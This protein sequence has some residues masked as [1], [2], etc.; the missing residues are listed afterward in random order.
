MIRVRLQ[1]GLG[2]QMFQYALG[3]T[4]AARHKVPLVLDLSFYEQQSL[5]RFE[6]EAFNIQADIHKSRRQLFRESPLN[7]LNL[8]SLLRSGDNGTGATMLLEDT[9]AGVDA[10]VFDATPPLVLDGYWASYQYWRGWDGFRTDFTLRKP[11]SP[12]ACQWQH[13]IALQPSAAIHVRRG[14]YVNDPKTSAFH[15]VQGVDYYRE[16]WKMLAARSGR[17]RPFVFTDDPEWAEANL[18]FLP[19]MAVVR[20]NQDRPAE[21]L[22][23]MSQCS[24]HIIANSTFSWWGAWLGQNPGQVVIAPGRWLKNADP[25]VRNLVPNEWQVL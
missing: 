2:N 1:G 19:E 5:R 6:L 18:D 16:A 17:V 20:G 3:R 24:H 7:P 25:H 13:A 23:L 21:D 12:S 22:I 8:I 9:T 15:H 10:R 14:D 4:L 11:L